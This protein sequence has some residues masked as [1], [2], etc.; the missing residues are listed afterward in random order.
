MKEDIPRW[1]SELPPFR[2]R[3]ARPHMPYSLYK[4]LR[5]M[6]PND[7]VGFEALPLF[8]DTCIP[9]VTENQVIRSSLDSLNGDEISEEK[10]NTISRNAT[11]LGRQNSG[12]KTTSPTIGSIS[13]GT[14]SLSR[15]GSLR[16]KPSAR[17]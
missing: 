10:K 7:F 14:A 12:N 8:S 1:Q 11:T 3:K 5:N 13:K 17:K 9:G 4:M 15:F 2:A 16:R 6:F